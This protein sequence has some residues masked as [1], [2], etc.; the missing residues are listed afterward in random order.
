MTQPK[1][2]GDWMQTYTGLEFYPLDPRV[3]DIRID[4]IA[5]AL[6]KACRYSGHCIRFYSVA[7]HCVHIAS[8]APDHLKLTA[9]MHDAPEAYLVD[10]PRPIKP[11]LPGYAEIEERLANVIALRFDLIHPLPHEVKTLDNAILD[12]ERVQNMAQPPR[13][14]GDHGGPLGV[15]LKFWTPAEAKYQFATAFYR[16][17]G[18]A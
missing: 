15:T 7:E 1:R 5:S 13:P 12:D 17:G 14:W 9:L 18:R 11:H 4:D 6:S 10:V 16:Y 3:E 2:R 8:K